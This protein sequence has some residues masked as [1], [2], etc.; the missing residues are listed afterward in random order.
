MKL[1]SF[2]PKGHGQESFFVIAENEDEAKSAINKRIEELLQKC[3][4]EEDVP[5][6]EDD[7][8]GWGTE[9][10][11]LTIYEIGQVAL[12]NND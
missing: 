3:E 6:G 7:F 2:T 10:Y 5:Y 1:Y 4:D 12:H 8:Q 11:R 9:Y